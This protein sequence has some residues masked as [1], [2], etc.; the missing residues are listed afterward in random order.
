[1]YLEHRQ[2]SDILMLHFKFIHSSHGDLYSAS[3]R[4]LLRSA[5]N[6]KKKSFEVGV[7]CVRERILGSNRCA[8]ESPFHTEGTT[9]ENARVWLVEVRAKGTKSNPRSIERSELR[10]LVPGVGQHTYVHT[11]IHT[12]IHTYLHTYIQKR[13]GVY[14]PPLSKTQMMA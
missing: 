9:T 1:M 4:L 14:Q 10:P 2:K 8:K 6:P 12:Y 13:K 7:E 5:P 11:Y 3:S